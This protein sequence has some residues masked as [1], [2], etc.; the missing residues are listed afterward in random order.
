M[1]VRDFAIQFSGL[2]EGEH[3]FSYQLDKAFFALFDEEQIHD[4]QVE[5]EVTMNRQSR[6]LQFYFGLKG[7][8]EVTCDRCADPLNI[9]VEGREDLIVRIGESGESDDDDIVFI[10][11]DE[12][13]FDLSQHLF[14]Y[15]HMLLPM[16][17][18]HEESADGRSC[19]PE[20]LKLLERYSTDKPAGNT[21][22]GLEKLLEDHPEDQTNN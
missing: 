10:S 22:R 12:F 11:E 13:E 7:V 16:R 5:V 2:A 8:V 4:G 14:D 19:D 15:V 21:W 6:M 17:L 18:T 3:H 1:A 9:A 20:M